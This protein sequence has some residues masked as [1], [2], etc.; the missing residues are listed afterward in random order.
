MLLR[1]IAAL[2]ALIT[3]APA[4][5]RDLIPP[6]HRPAVHELVFD[7]LEL[8]PGTRLVAT[9]VRGF[10][11]VEE[12]RAGVPFRFSSKYGTTFFL[13]PENEDITAPEPSSGLAH[14]SAPP[15]VREIRSLP[16]VNPV[17]RVLTT[18]AF[19]GV[20]AGELRLSA[21]REERFDATGEPVGVGTYAPWIAVL[22]LGVIAVHKLGQR[23]RRAS[24]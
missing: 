18:L 22:L 20:E 9:P 23:R 21:V 16:L 8:P 17:A 24:A 19:E 3:A 14:P 4:G 10:G 6:G 1:L 7:R 13:V 11:G 15:P 2:A 12:V 5:A